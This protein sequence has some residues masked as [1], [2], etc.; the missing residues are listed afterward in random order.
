MVPLDLAAEVPGG[1]Q[2]VVCQAVQAEFH[3]LADALADRPQQLPI[4]PGLPDELTT[5]QW[6]PWAAISRARRAKC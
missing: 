2:V 6:K 3:P 5:W 4:Q 1:L